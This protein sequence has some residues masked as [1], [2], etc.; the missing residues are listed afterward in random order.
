MTRHKKNLTEMI[1]NYNKSGQKE[2]HGQILKRQ[3][4]LEKAIKTELKKKSWQTYDAM[5]EAANRLNKQL[6]I[7]TLNFDQ[8]KGIFLTNLNCLI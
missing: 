7:A 3:K 6:C 2:L 4:R 1:R 5:E 8:K